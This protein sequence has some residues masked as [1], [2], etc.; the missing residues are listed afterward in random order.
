MIDG[1]PAAFEA[2]MSRRSPY[3]I[4]PG[5][6]TGALAE[7]SEAAANAAQNLLEKAFARLRD[8]D[9]ERADRLIARV[10]ALPYDEH[11]ECWHGTA[12]AGQLLFTQLTSI[13]EEWADA[14]EF[15][16]EYTSVYW[17]HED[18]A[19]AVDEMDPGHLAVLRE[20]LETISADAALLGVSPREARGLAEVAKLMPPP[21]LPGAGW[22]IPPDADELQ[23]EAVIRRYLDV[24]IDVVRVLETSD[25]T[26]E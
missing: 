19:R 16:D 18:M 9:D 7:M 26:G 2:E 15:P 25:F 5:A 10:V 12:M 11:A 22:E 14:Q 23:R 24:L 20:T 1:L 17:L 4:H 3:G 13:A 6:K 8:G 21:A